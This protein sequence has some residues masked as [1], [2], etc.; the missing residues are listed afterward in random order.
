MKKLKRKIL[1]I[2][3]A[4][5]LVP[6]L[7]SA[8]CPA[9]YAE[10]DTAQNTKGTPTYYHVWVSGV[11]VSSEN[12]DN[13]LGDTNKSVR[14][15]PETDT[16]IL[17]NPIITDSFQDSQIYATIDL[18]ITGKANLNLD[19]VQYGICANSVTI[20]KG[21]IT[22]RA[23]GKTGI[24]IRTD[25]NIE[26]SGGTVN[27][28]G[29]M[30]GMYSHEG[31]III[32][33]GDVTA[34]GPGMAGILAT[35]DLV[36]TGGTV[37]AASDNNGAIGSGMASYHKNVVIEGGDIT[38]TGFFRGIHCIHGDITISGGTVRATATGDYNE[39]AG[40]EVWEDNNITI[41]GG[42]VEAKG[43]RTGI[44]THEGEITIS[45]G[46]VTA[47]GNRYGIRSDSSGAATGGN[48]TFSGDDTIVT[49]EGQVSAVSVTYPEKTII[50]KSP[51]GIV[52]P[53]SGMVKDN[54]IY[55]A[56]GTTVA[57]VAVI[58]KACK[59]T[60]D[61]NGHGTAPLPQYVA[62]NSKAA[63]PSDITAEG[64]TFD[65]WYTDA[66]CTDL[67]DF[68]TPVT[69]EITLYA[70]WL[71]DVN[72]T[73]DV[74]G[75]GTA[76]ETQQ[77][78]YGGTAS[79]PVNPWEEGYTFGGWYTDAACTAPYDFST[80][81]TGDIV[82]YAR[83][84]VNVKGLKMHSDGG[85]VDA[86][87]DYYLSFDQ[88]EPVFEKDP[89]SVDMTY[90]PLFTDEACTDSMKSEP[91]QG[92]TYYFQ[93]TMTDPSSVNTGVQRMIFLP[94]IVYNID[95]SAE[96]A[97]IEYVSFS[98]SPNGD[99]AILLF[100]YT[101]SVIEYT[102]TKGADAEWTKG[103]SEGVDYTVTRNINDDK[104]YGLFEG[105]EIDGTVIDASNYTAASGSLN[106]TLN[107][108]YLET[109]S[110]GTHT[111]KFSFKD[112]SVETTLTIK[113]KPAPAPEPE[114]VK[115]DTPVTPDTGDNTHT[116]LWGGLLAVSLLSMAGL[117]FFR[118]RSAG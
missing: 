52:T 58:R 103:S 6:G 31:K 118:K 42:T 67:Y 19:N 35:D 113:D 69:K 2:L 100:K 79:K 10:E 14:F 111:V 61:A 48:I 63:K 76:P 4:V 72:V 47:T 53:V 65:G 77:I 39:V 70:K 66:A 114:P 105:I 73:F 28:W 40:L 13:V 91:E 15:D 24:A 37:K 92:T 41:S 12:K 82:L 21:D 83:W 94:K 20:E 90:S 97:M 68:D 3:T 1:G 33:G 116:G 106:A 78:K 62:Y 32:S 109:L 49:A 8:S 16:L 80:S 34:E 56:D 26:I 25:K 110:A 55:K 75:H 59:V 84:M 81:L 5:M 44:R 22:V 74:Q 57:T 18:T 29:E 107:A 54:E 23:N 86:S 108:P 93:V 38:A 104:T 9:A 101:H 11:S 117:M 115:P 87:G 36:I 64:Y 51:L 30:Y 98:D 43:T 60:F 95:A 99:T 96:E 45:G 88:L 85:N 50:I 89:D 71:A 7:L 17:N 46:N 102:V 27:A 112:G